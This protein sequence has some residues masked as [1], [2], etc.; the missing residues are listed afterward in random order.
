[1]PF[2]SKVWVRIRV[3]MRF[4]V[5]LKSC[6]A[7]VFVRLYVVIV[8]DRFMASCI[9]L[10]TYLLV[11]LRIYLLR[12]VFLVSEKRGGLFKKKAAK[13]ARAMDDSGVDTIQKLGVAMH[14]LRRQASDTNLA[15]ASEYSR[16]AA[17]GAKAGAG[18]TM[19]AGATG[20]GKRSKSPF[21]KFLRTKSQ[22]RDRPE[23][24][25]ATQSMPMHITVSLY[26]F[27]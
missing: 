27:A 16:A 25:R 20:T 15:G 9:N 4:S 12:N 23:D 2:G 6:Y 10:L 18:A 1:M 7:H 5:W 3:R 19:P 24:S 8:T 21:A 26:S 11:W 13:P 22:E 14:P 17:G